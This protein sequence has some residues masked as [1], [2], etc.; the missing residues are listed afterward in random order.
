MNYD[1]EFK[2]ILSDAL[3]KYLI[4]IWDGYLKE[5]PAATMANTCVGDWLEYINREHTKYQ[6]TLK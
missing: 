5:H 3:G 4:D 1:K 2:K 6:S